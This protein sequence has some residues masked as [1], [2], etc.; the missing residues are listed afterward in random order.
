MK[1]DEDLATLRDDAQFKEL[2]D[3][4]HKNERAA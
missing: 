1:A 3:K 4:A 2:L